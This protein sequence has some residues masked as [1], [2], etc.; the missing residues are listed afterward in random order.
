[1]SK[2][3]REEV[4]D[5]A[6]AQALW[7]DGIRSN[8]TSLKEEIEALETQCKHA[9]QALW[10]RRSSLAVLEKEL[11]FRQ[12]DVAQK[13]CLQAQVD[14]LLPK[15]CLI[16]WVALLRQYYTFFGERSY[17]F[18][19]PDH[20]IAKVVYHVSQESNENNHVVLSY[21]Q[22]PNAL[23]YAN[24][25]FFRSIKVGNDGVREHRSCNLGSDNPRQWNLM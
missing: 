4:N 5:A 10:E 2:R 12:L 1:M 25:E 15:S 13:A 18:L 20:K 24:G 17:G 14:G 16:K 11:K 9:E 23:L 19:N 6:V 22:G 7:D 8:I 21:G 3:T